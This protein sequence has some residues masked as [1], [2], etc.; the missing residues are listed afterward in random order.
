MILKQEYKDY[1]RSNE[2]LRASNLYVK[3]L[4]VDIDD[5]RLEE[6]FSAYGKI[7]SAKV[8]CHND[9]TSRQFGFVCF[10]SPEE[11]N[12]ALVALHGVL[13]EG[14]IL[15][16]AKAQCKKDH[17][18]ER[19]NF[20]EQNQPQ[21]FYPSNCNI[22]S[23][24]IHPLHFN[25]DRPPQLPFLHR[26]M[27]CQQ[28]G[29]N[30]GVQHPFMPQIYQQKFS[31]YMPTAKI[32]LGSTFNTRDKPYQQHSLKFATPNFSNRDLKLGSAGGQKLD[33]K[34]K[35]GKRGAAGENISTGSP[36]TK[37]LPAAK[38]TDST[39]ID[40][41]NLLQ[42]IVKKLPERHQKALGNDQ[43]ECH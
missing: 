34:K 42:P 24:A 22:V 29:A 8:M 36:S 2:K 15:H 16:V 5:K 12:K 25:F 4:N 37:C 43:I 26:P 21:F 18:Q 32:F 40:F 17:H 41:G 13:L 31:T 23:S 6:V 27:F 9:G 3:N 30:F 35:G 11:A 1:N 38:S 7:L 10:A 20:S 28:F 19:H 39:V 33:S 14:K